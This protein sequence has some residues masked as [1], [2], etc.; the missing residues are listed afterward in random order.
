VFRLAQEDPEFLE[1]IQQARRFSE[2]VEDN[3]DIL[4]DAQAFAESLSEE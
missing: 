4:E 1:D 3:P 2:L